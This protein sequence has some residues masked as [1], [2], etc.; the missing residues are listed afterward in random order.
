MDNQTPISKMIDAF[1][2]LGVEADPV[3]NL[4]RKQ[5]TVR[6]A[7]GVCEG[8]RII[9]SCN[10]QSI[11]VLDSTDKLILHEGYIALYDEDDFKRIYTTIASSIDFKAP[12]GFDDLTDVDFTTDTDNFV[13]PDGFDD[14]T[15]EADLIE[16]TD[17]DTEG[18]INDEEISWRAGIYPTVNASVVPSYISSCRVVA[19]VYSDTTIAYR[20]KTNV[21]DYD[22]NSVVARKYGLTSDKVTKCTRL[23]LIN[24]V[25][26][27]KGEK[28]AKRLI[29][30]VSNC[31]EDCNKLISALLNG[32]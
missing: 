2:E 32:E 3:I 31:I 6:I 30:D 20:F 28:E 1:R 4:A 5:I 10:T 23:L 29:P 24:G 13:A 8:V 17:T 14:L 12:D 22:M 26:M 11:D 19:L 18:I 25:Y 7:N 27:T 15:D 21:G 9:Y 16:S